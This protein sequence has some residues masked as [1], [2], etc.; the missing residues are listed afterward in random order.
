M[1]IFVL[2]PFLC[3][4]VGCIILT[5][6]TR[7]V[8]IRTIP[9]MISLLV[10]SLRSSHE[11]AQHIK[12]HKALFTAM[13]TTLGVGNIVGPI[14]AIGIGG[15]GTML[16]YVLATLFGSAAT[17]AEVTFAQKYQDPSP[18]NKTGGAM[19]Y[20]KKA[21]PSSLVMLYASAGFIMLLSWSAAQSNAL[22]VI[23]SAYHIPPI[24][25]GLCMAVATLIVLIGGIKRIGSL[26]EL[27]VPPMFIIYICAI[28]WIIACNA[29]SLPSVLR[30]IVTSSF[31]PKAF[32][33]GSLTAGIVN[34]LRWGL[35]RG[36]HSNESGLGTAAIPHSKAQCSQATDQ[37]VL[38][39][40]S[41]FSNGLIC[42]LTGLAFLLS[43]MNAHYH[44]ESITVLTKLFN[45]YLPGIG[46]LVLIISIS[47]FVITTV[48][49][50]SYN[51]SQLFRY[52]LGKKRINLYYVLCAICIFLGSLFS[53]NQIAVCVDILALPVI[54]PHILGLVIMSFTHRKDLEI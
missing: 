52:A 45:A 12:A 26:A 5:I 13:A 27:M 24:Y 10:K 22:S 34:S 28:T 33:T 29:S 7:C 43:G 50:N 36:F 47:L 40:L 9:R 23:L 25:T 15:P 20:L 42:I 19:Y 17:F 16:G 32:A 2:L 18:H 4:L 30:M 53:V 48:I 41:V 51:G 21:L 35:A 49:G 8:Q 6:Q 31:A 1:T 38:A 44:S 11:D 14:I 39:I 37:G 3:L 54:I 46:P